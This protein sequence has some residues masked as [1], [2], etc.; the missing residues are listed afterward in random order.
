M[1][2][3]SKVYILMLENIKNE[4]EILYEMLYSKLLSENKQFITI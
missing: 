4:G 2:K 1:L 3:D